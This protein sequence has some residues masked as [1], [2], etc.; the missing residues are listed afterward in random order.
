MHKSVP[1]PSRPNL[2]PRATTGFLYSLRLSM[3]PLWFWWHRLSSLWPPRGETPR[4]QCF[5]RGGRGERGEAAEAGM[6]RHGGRTG[7]ARGPAPTVLGPASANPV[8]AGPRARPGQSARGRPRPTAG[9]LHGLRLSSLC[10]GRPTGSPLRSVGRVAKTPRRQRARRVVP[11]QPLVP[12]TSR[13]S[14]YWWHRLSSPVAPPRPT[15][16]WHRLSSLCAG[17]AG[18]TRRVVRGR[19]GNYR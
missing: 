15:G 4:P 3:P 6:G 14:P 11:L 19:V 18:A 7:Q 10:L 9:L 5:H 17:R 2:P 8:G 1:K 16:W 12:P 13:A